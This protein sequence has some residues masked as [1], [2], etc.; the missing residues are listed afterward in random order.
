MN[1]PNDPFIL[2][3]V[4]NTKLRDCYS[5]LDSM[6]EDLDIDKQELV[7]KL[8][9]AGFRYDISNNAFKE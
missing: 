9:N 5:S 7:E 4:V 1:L 6:C 3:S 8:G 2:L